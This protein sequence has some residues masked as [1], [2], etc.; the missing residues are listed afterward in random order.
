[1]GE[2]EGNENDVGIAQQENINKNVKM[3]DKEFFNLSFRMEGK[4]REG[5]INVRHINQ[6]PP[7][8]ARDPDMCPD[9][10]SHMK[11]SGM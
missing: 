4:G 6:P 9:L 5:N 2:E 10:A 11:P 1:M 3:F 8:C 7:T